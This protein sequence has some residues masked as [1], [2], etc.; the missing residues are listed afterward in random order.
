MLLAFTEETTQ[1]GCNMAMLGLSLLISVGMLLA[2]DESGMVLVKVNGVAI[3]TTDVDFAASQQALSAEERSAT[4]PRLVERLID[5]QLIR[6]FLAS[7]KIE[8]LTDDLQQQVARAEELIRKR[9]NDPEKLLA[10]LGYTPAR[11]KRELGLPLA[12]QM[13]VRQTV[14]PLQMKEYFALHKQELDGTQV[15][16]SQIFLKV[17]KE[18]SEADI[19]TIKEQLS[20]LRTD[21]E[22]KKLTFAEAAKQQSQAPTRNQGGDVGLFGWRGKLPATVSQ[23]AFRLKVG[24]ISEPV[25][26]PFGIHLIQVTERHPG[27]F[28]LEDVR[29]VILD[30]LSS[31]RWTETLASERATAKIEWE[32]K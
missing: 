1:E 15:R 29:P 21:I 26:S 17:P 6:A 18:A 30:R 3:T 22:L 9:G 24:E 28:S 20:A 23:A 7:K 2:T 16:A 13:Y 14:S 12:W 11:L 25:V 4:E 27:D 19:A 8:P 10:Q 31:Q 32:K 5:R